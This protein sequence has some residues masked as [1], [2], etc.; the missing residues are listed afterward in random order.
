MAYGIDEL[1]EQKTDAYRGNPA[2]LEQRSKM[3]NELVDLLALQKLKS[4]KDAA[5]RNM[6]MQ[7][8]TQP[9]TIAK[10]LEA[11]MVGRTKDEV[12]QGVSGVLATN[13]A[14]QRQRMASQGIAPQPR[15]NMQRMAQG[16]IVGFQEGKQVESPYTGSRSRQREDILRD[17]EAGTISQEKADELISALP[18][19][20][21]FSGLEQIGRA[22]IP[23]SLRDKIPEDISDAI[24][25][26]A[27]KGAEFFIGTDTMTSPVQKVLRSKTA[28]VL[29]A[30]DLVDKGLTLPFSTPEYLFTPTSDV[31]EEAATTEEPVVEPPV[32]QEQQTTTE[33]EKDPL[34]EG[35]AG[36]QRIAVP[37]RG[38]LDAGTAALEAQ[39]RALAS[40]LAA[41]DPKAE[42]AEG[43]AFAEKALG[44]EEKAEQYADMMSRLEALNKEQMD[45][46]KLQNERL[47]ATLLG[48]QG[49]TISQA[50]GSSGR[51]GMEAGRQQEIAK[52]QRVMDELNLQ[53]KAIEV[54]V[55]LGKSA[56]GS[57]NFAL[58]Q[59]AA[60]RR[61]GSEAL[62][63]ITGEE[64]TKLENEVK[65]KL[66]ANIANLRADT[67]MLK[68]M[69]QAADRKELARTTNIN[70]LQK[71]MDSINTKLL[72]MYD[73]Q[74]AD[75]LGFQTAL[76]Q[77]AVNVSK[78]ASAEELAK[79]QAAVDAARE[80][81]YTQIQYAASMSGVLTSRAGLEKRLNE[82]LNQRGDKNTASA[83]IT[84]SNVT[85]ITKKSP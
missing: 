36:L 18:S 67:E 74:M 1:I 71:Q 6:Q 80:N 31:P 12:L 58:Q 56:I 41:I 13:Q 19:P 33:P 9:D 29:A 21:V 83:G 10:Q 70:A 43:L 28:D 34:A 76:R 59:A 65:N 66:D 84:S 8:Q 40:N 73:N 15:P 57:A 47:M 37:K 54:D 52:R 85:G 45:P 24:G 79:S 16:G 25:E 77:H 20:T 26:A 64:K 30:A 63:K 42:R 39:R 7:V 48:A 81:L 11:E 35:I 23:R 69:S 68:L 46:D 2:A 32:E 75:D 22:M 72:E 44:R 60:D 5:A 3:S 49:S 17:L 14:R 38:E 78:G 82:L 51:A 61:Q 27:V 50:L 62:G 4:E 55:D 53:S